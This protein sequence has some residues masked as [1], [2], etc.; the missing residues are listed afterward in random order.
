MS[1]IIS[2]ACAL[3][4]V[5]P[6]A[7][8]IAYGMGAEAGLSRMALPGDVVS[9]AN[10]DHCARQRD[11]LLDDLKKTTASL[12]WALGELERDRIAGVYPAPPPSATREPTHD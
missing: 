9:R 1:L 5:V 3:G 4:I 11:G 7:I 6:A 10:F 2:M 8:I 12:K